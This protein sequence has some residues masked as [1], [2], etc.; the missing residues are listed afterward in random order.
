MSIFENLLRKR[1]KVYITY[2]YYK[3][4]LKA[5]IRGF[6]KNLKKGLEF[7]QIKLATFKLW[8]NRGIDHISDFI[9]DIQLVVDEVLTHYRI[10]K[11]NRL[12]SKLSDKTV[13]IRNKQH[14]INLKLGNL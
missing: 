2:L 3:D 8:I 9:T 10:N 6:L 4:L 7:V 5:K 14:K 12:E 11:F 1:N 13:K